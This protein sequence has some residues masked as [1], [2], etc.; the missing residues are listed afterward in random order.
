MKITLLPFQIYLYFLFILTT[1]SDHTLVKI[2]RKILKRDPSAA[3]RLFYNSQDT[4]DNPYKSKKF[5][6]GL[7]GRCASISPSG[8]C[9]KCECKNVDDTFLSYKHGC[10]GKDNLFK[11][12]NG[13]K[14]IS[15]TQFNF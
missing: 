4:F 10:L 15:C 14:Y 1:A 12:T 11:A 9:G 7:N 13:K 5:C 3:Y 6:R 8:Y 2:E